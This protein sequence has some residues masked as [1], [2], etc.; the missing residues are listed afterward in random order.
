[1]N[2]RLDHIITAAA[3]LDARPLWPRFGLTYTYEDD[4]GELVLPV[5]KRARPRDQ[6]TAGAVGQPRLI[7]KDKSAP[8]AW[9]PGRS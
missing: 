6:V 4:N 3:N 7:R 1:M 2:S 8:K 5:G 9:Q